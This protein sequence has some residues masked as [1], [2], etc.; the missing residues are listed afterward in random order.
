MTEPQSKGAWV[1]EILP[2]GDTPVVQKQQFG[3]LHGREI[4]LYCVRTIINLM[5]YLFLNLICSH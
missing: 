2:G 3:L 4:N 1:A 5:V